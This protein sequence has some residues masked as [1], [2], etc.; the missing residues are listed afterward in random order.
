MRNVPWLQEMWHHCVWLVASH[1]W[2]PHDDHREFAQKFAVSVEGKTWNKNYISFRVWWIEVVYDITMFTSSLGL[3]CVSA[4]TFGYLCCV[5]PQRFDKYIVFKY[6]WLLHIVNWN[7]PTGLRSK[8]L[9]ATKLTS[10]IFLC[11]RNSIYL[12]TS[13]LLVGH[14]AT[15]IS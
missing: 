12:H 13:I 15:G 10:R 1:L 7:I 6:H 4:Q 11:G 9:K 14:G 2:N 3:T 8:F 5:I